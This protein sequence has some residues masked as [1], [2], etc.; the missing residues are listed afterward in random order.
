MAGALDGAGDRLDLVVLEGAAVEQQTAVADDA[1]DRRLAETERRSKGL[2]DGAGEALELR[3]R[4]RTA[5]HA[6]DGLLDLARDERRQT[7]GASPDRA[8][9]LLEHAQ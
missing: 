9:C 6:R 4:Q 8:A 5:A 1:D 2:L 7:L 3:E